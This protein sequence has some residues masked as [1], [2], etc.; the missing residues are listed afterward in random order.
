MQEYLCQNETNHFHHAHSP[1]WIHYYLILL[2]ILGN[3]TGFILYIRAS[4][5]HLRETTKDE[6]IGPTA[7]YYQGCLEIEKAWYRPGTPYTSVKH[8]FVTWMDFAESY[9]WIYFSQNNHYQKSCHQL[10]QLK[11]L[12][13]QDSFNSTFFLIY[14]LLFFIH[15]EKE[16][17]NFERQFSKTRKYYWKLFKFNF[18]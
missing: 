14:K 11:G 7:N 18:E 16:E 15:I 2:H 13:P 8:S 10:K 1:F 4:K 9:I 17:R 6:L 12:N 5:F 3:A